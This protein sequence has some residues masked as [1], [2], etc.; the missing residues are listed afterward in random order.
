MLEKKLVFVEGNR[1]WC[2]SASSSPIMCSPAKD[3]P[4]STSRSLAR[5]AGLIKMETILGF[6]RKPRRISIWASMH[7]R[8]A[9]CPSNPFVPYPGKEC[10]IYFLFFFRQNGRCFPS[11]HSSFFRPQRRE[12]W[13]PHSSPLSHYPP[14]ARF[15]RISRLDVTICF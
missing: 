11:R 6:D 12:V 13:P 8:Y 3:W 7:A 10:H 15:R 4:R 2:G 5:P 9:M 14:Y 1:R